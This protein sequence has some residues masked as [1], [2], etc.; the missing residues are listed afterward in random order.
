LSIDV[1]FEADER[2][3]EA[4]LIS[5][6]LE[7]GGSQFE[8]KNGL[9]GVSFASGMSAYPRSAEGAPRIKAED[10]RDA[11]FRVGSRCIFRPNGGEYDASL[12][13]LEEVLSLVAEKNGAHFVVSFQLEEALFVN[14]GK[15]VERCP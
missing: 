5:L 1:W 14:V 2:L 11:N 9:V 13:E 8:L 12:Q 7:A 10:P 4:E 6:L 15:G 3:V